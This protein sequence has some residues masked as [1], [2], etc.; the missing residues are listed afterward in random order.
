MAGSEYVGQ[1]VAFDTAKRFAQVPQ[2]PF[3]MFQIRQSPWPHCA[4]ILPGRGPL[5]VD[6]VLTDQPLQLVDG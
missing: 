1:F 4:L 3:K 5:A 6:P 2:Q